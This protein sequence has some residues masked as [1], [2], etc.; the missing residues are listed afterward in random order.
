MGATVFAGVL[1]VNGDG[2]RQLREQAS[3]NLQV[4]RLDVTDSAHIEA[5]RRYI[6]TQVAGTGE[7]E[8]AMSSTTLIP[9]IQTLNSSQARKLTGL[10]F[11]FLVL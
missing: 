9:G 8:R 5:A 4:L 6:R 10:I 7:T 2:A 1:D 11:Q 3:G